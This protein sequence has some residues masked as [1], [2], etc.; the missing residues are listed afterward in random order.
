[1]ESLRL[2][3]DPPPHHSGCVS[4][5]PLQGRR[6]WLWVMASSLCPSEGLTRHLSLAQPLQPEIFTRLEGGGA[7]TCQ[8]DIVGVPR[9]GTR[10]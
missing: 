9:H 2:M 3:G 8:G 7:P 10:L 1:M 6:A 5:R 4:G